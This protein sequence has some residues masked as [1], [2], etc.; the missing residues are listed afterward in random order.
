MKKILFIFGLV[1]LTSIYSC[2]KEQEIDPIVQ[3]ID[4]AFLY[5]EI[6]FEFVIG[7]N[8][9]Y[10]TLYMKDVWLCDKDIIH[11]ETFPSHIKED[12]GNGVLILE[13]HVKKDTD[14]IKYVLW[15]KTETETE[16][17][18]SRKLGDL[19]YIES[20]KENEYQLALEWLEGN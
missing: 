1:L 15:T 11:D 6:T 8:A 14:I 13:Q 16:I 7:Q 3:S 5:S 18:Q 19:D 10:D 2:Q 17:Y 12:Y 20:I 4:R 9:T